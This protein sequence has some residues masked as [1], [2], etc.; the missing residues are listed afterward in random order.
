MFAPAGP[1]VPRALAALDKGGTCALAG[2]YMTPIPELDYGRLLY[3]ERTLRSVANSTRQ[4]ME[5]LL[6]L[7]GEIP[8]RTEVQVFPLAEANRALWELKRGGIRGAAV[9]AVC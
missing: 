7:A 9:L 3:H 8:L 2:I 6:R 5:E 1:L 4:D